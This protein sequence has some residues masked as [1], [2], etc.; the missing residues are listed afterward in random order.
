[1]KINNIPENKVIISIKSIFKSILKQILNKI[2][3]IK[4]ILKYS[5]GDLYNGEL[6]NNQKK[7]DNGVKKFKI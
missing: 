1:M 4:K 2:F 5:N 6:D 3:Y 7:N